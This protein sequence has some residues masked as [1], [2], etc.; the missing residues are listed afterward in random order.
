LIIGGRDAEN[1]FPVVYIND[2]DAAAQ[3]RPDGQHCDLAPT[4]L[5]LLRVP[6]AEDLDGSSLLVR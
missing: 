6:Q 5:E 2:A 1:R 3:L 4:L